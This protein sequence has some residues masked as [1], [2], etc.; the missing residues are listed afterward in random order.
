MNYFRL[1][2]VFILFLGLH[3]MVTAQKKFGNCRELE[4]V[5]MNA[6][7]G[8]NRKMLVIDARLY[9]DFHKKHVTGA[10]NAP[11]DK[12]LKAIADSIDS[13]SI[14]VVYGQTSDESLDAC[15]WMAQQ[16]LTEVYSLRGGFLA[17]KQLGYTVTKGK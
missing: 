7:L 2:I 3:D 17:W 16:G 8:A 13:E 6:W 11:T 5:E 15:L 4:P 12:R 9:K 1:T 10:I 14:V